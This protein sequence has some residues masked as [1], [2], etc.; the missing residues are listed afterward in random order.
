MFAML[1]IPV[2]IPA[3]V[4][5][6][7]YLAYTVFAAHRRGGRVNHDA[8]LSGALAGLAFVAATDPAAFG[9]ALRQAFG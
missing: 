6:I 8:H 3:P 5:A 7:A 4:F 1:P 2:P 9:A